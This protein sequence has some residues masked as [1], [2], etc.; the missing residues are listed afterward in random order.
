MEQFT[1]RERFAYR[2]D[3]VVQTKG[4][5]IQLLILACIIFLCLSALAENHVNGEQAGYAEAAWA[6]WLYMADPGMLASAPPTLDARLVAL[7]VQIGGIV[8]FSI[9]VGFVADAV[10]EK[11]GALKKGRSSVVESGHTVML[12]WTPFSMVFIREVCDANSS[13]GGG[14]IVVLSERDK[15]DLEFEFYSLIKVE[16]LRGT[17]VVFRS[18]RPTNMADLLKV[19]CPMAKSVLCLTPSHDLSGKRIQADVA[20]A[21]T[22]QV[23]LAL[24]GLEDVQSH[25]LGPHIVAEIRDQDNEKIIQMVGAGK[26]ETVVSHDI[27]GKLMIMSARQPGLAKVLEEVLG[28]AGDEFYTQHWPETAGK[29]FGDLSAHFGDAIVIGLKTYCQAKHCKYKCQQPHGAKGHIVLNP[30]AD[31]VLS[32]SDQVIV[33]AEDNDTYSYDAGALGVEGGVLP[34]WSPPTKSPPECIL[35]AGWR[36]DIRDV[37][38]FLDVMVA[39]GTEVHML[40]GL[41]LAERAEVLLQEGLDVNTLMNI[42]LVHYEGNATSRGDLE[43]LPLALYTSVL[44]L[45]DEAHEH[46][47]MHSDSHNL[48]SLLLLRNVQQNLQ[49]NGEIIRLPPCTTEILDSRTQQTIST[50]STVFAGADFVQSNELL[51]QMLAMISEDPA[52]NTILGELLGSSGNDLCLEPCAQYCTPSER[53]S[54]AQLAKRCHQAKRHILCGYVHDKGAGAVV[55][56]PRDKQIEKVWDGSTTLIAIVPPDDI[57]MKQMERGDLVLAPPRATAW[58]RMVGMEGQVDLMTKQLRVVKQLVQRRCESR[59][60]EMKNIDALIETEIDKAEIKNID[61]LIETEIHISM[62]PQKSLVE[63][64][65][66]S[67]ENEPAAEDSSVASMVAGLWE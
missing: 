65:D 2:L 13:E 15:E 12:G 33:I 44:V 14:T 62:G 20:D 56:N 9:I 17:D 43:E 59:K 22:L 58:E 5:Q 34:D 27:I 6:S 37:L 47:M 39:E 29:K 4:G 42:T 16:E 40:A 36:R 52:V 67:K 23:I 25:Q 32:P 60:A 64:I 45:A 19:S 61:A 46:D 48:N 18:G 55:V 54:F 41:P 63:Q 38:T 30:A 1:R 26:V 7:F 57:P 35:M 21:M 66:S 10:K 8:F 49:T 3:T 11:M 51:S 50:G 31:L 24:R 28:F 53:I